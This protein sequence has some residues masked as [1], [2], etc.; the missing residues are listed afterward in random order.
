MKYL[1]YYIIIL[2]VCANSCKPELPID[3]PYTVK[4]SLSLAKNNKSELEDVIRHYSRYK[5]DSLKLKAVYFLIENMRWHSSKKIINKSTDLL[6]IINW[7]DAKYYKI[8]QG[9]SLNSLKSDEYARK[10]EAIAILAQQKIENLIFEENIEVI[11]S[12][13]D[14]ELLDSDF[15]INHVNN[16]FNLK[17]SSLVKELSFEEFCEYILTY[18]IIPRMNIAKSG[19]DYNNIFAKYIE[20]KNNNEDALMDNLERLKLTIKNFRKILGKYPY[21]QKLGFEEVFFINGPEFDCYDMVNIEGAILK[22]CGIPVKGV[23]NLSFKNRSGGHAFLS[24][25][26]KYSNIEGFIPE[27]YARAGKTKYFPGYKDRTNFFEWHFEI[28]KNNPHYLGSSDSY[29]PPELSGPGIEDVSYWWAPTTSIKLPFKENTKNHLAYLA[30]FNNPRGLICITWGTINKNSMT[31]EFSNVLPN[32]LYFPIYFEKDSMR[33]FGKPF[34]FVFDTI[35]NKFD[36]VYFDTKKNENLR[37]VY[38]LRK[39]PQ[40]PNLVQRAKNLIGTVVVASNTENFSNADTLFKLNFHP[41]PYFQD[42]KFNNNRPYK[43]YMIDAP[44]NKPF[45]EIS[46]IEYLTNA[47]YNYKNVTTPTPLPVFNYYDTITNDNYNF[48][49]IIDTS[50]NNSH[51]EYDGNQFTVTKGAKDVKL[52]LKIPQVITAIRFTPIN[53]L[54]GIYPK[55][56]YTLYVW[57]TDRWKVISTQTAVYNFLYFNNLQTNTLYWLHNKFSGREELPFILDISG[58]QMFIYYDKINL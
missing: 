11:D 30:T 15:L 24:L 57:D 47:T 34:L 51:A 36:F 22:S 18:R 55:D 46:E 1:N 42:M 32:T 16:A 13:S 7:V 21:S 56:V 26:K 6:S 17:K 44:A 2:L 52:K 38:L 20:I 27:D 25:P 58:K 31:A 41:G 35:S 3:L 4:E 54:N 5:K 14:L 33:I 48:V 43:Y 29:I 28:Q 45:M 9:K 10:V 8:A 40:K 49:K 37:E 50:I 23:Y 12:V 19:R 39:Y 53:S